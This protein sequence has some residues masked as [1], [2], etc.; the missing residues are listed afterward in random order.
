MIQYQQLPTSGVCKDQ[1]GPISRPSSESLHS[2]HWRV[3]HRLMRHRRPPSDVRQ[4]NT[5]FAAM[6]AS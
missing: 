6:S 4:T 5:P 1:V 2:A 3:L